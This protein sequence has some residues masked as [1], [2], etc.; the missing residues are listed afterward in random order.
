ML[1]N[2]LQTPGREQT[3]RPAGQARS[4]RRGFARIAPRRRARAFKFAATR[5]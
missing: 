4:I 1:C 5:G 2:A 3:R